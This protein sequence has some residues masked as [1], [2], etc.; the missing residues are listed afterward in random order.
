M[1]SVLHLHANLRKAGKAFKRN[2]F[3]YLCIKLDITNDANLIIER[4]E[5]GP[6]YHNQQ[7]TLE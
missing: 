3:Y 2:N 7:H 1:I 6:N 4:M 5:Y